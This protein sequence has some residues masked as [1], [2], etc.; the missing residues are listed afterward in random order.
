MFNKEF[1]KSEIIKI[2]EHIDKNLDRLSEDRDFFMSNI[3]K[4]LR[5]LVESTTSFI[6]TIDNNIKGFEKQKIIEDAKKYIQSEYKYEFL[7][8]FLKSLQMTSSHY[9]LYSEY[10]ERMMLTYISYLVQLKQLL[11]DKYEICVLN[12]LTKFPLD[13]DCTFENYYKQI[14]E[15]LNSDNLNKSILSSSTFYIQK[16]KLMYID[17]SI[18]YEYTLTDALDNISKFNRFIAYSKIDML[19]NYAI[20]CCLEK[21]YVKLIEKDVPILII[22]VYDVAIRPCE[23]N[24]FAY[25]FGLK[26]KI[27]RND[28]YYRLMTYIRDNHC[29]I[30]RILEFSNDK[31]DT[32]I[33]SL[34]NNKR[35]SNLIILLNTARDFLLKKK[36]GYNVVKYLSA[37]LTNTII[38]NQLDNKANVNVSNLYLKSGVLIFE[39]TPY[40]GSLIRHNPQS[41]ILKDL[42][43]YEEYEDDVFANHIINES[44]NKGLIYFDATKCD[45][46]KAKSLSDRYN[47]RITLNE[48]R[49]LALYDKYIYVME[50]EVFSR[51]IIE[52]LIYKSSLVNFPDYESYIKYLLMN[53]TTLIDDDQ[54]KESIQTMYKNSSVYCIYGAA[55]TGKSTLISKELKLLGK[56]TKLCLTNTHSAL[57]NLRQRIDDSKVVYKTIKSFLATKNDE[58]K[59]DI[60]VIDECS[61]I[62]SKDMYEVLNKV[63][64]TL[65]LLAGD[66]YQLPAIQFGNRFALLRNFIS[67]NSYIDLEHVYRCNE[68]KL[69]SKVWDSVRNIEPRIKELLVSYRISNE[70]DESV[71]VKK[72][73]DEIILALNYDGVFGI[74]YL[75]KIL[76]INNPNSEVSWRHYTYKVGDPIVFN[77]TNRFGGHLYNNLKGTIRNIKVNDNNDIIF[78]IEINIVLSPFIDYPN[79]TFIRNSKDGKALIELKVLYSKDTDYDEDTKEAYKVPFEIA[80]ALSIHKAQGLEYNSVKLIIT[81]DVEE[82]ISHNVFY[83]AITRAKQSL[84]IYWS[85]QSEDYILKSFEKSNVYKDAHILANKFN[86]P[87]TKK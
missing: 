65:L 49:C 50:N 58:T 12:N 16:K 45:I 60:V 27:N 72:D 26:E 10:A 54:K 34:I 63:E 76:Q 81:K 4:F 59:Y 82:K 2:C 68:N 56:I 20:K 83:T 18:F 69:L 14:N 13:L 7:R 48:E 85:R 87:L 70:I 17:G 5:D 35:Q 57:Q 79:F 47:A 24:K 61:T 75:N 52:H 19:K 29:T 80:Y 6:Y 37:V 41:Y 84:T 71:Y 46:E 40:S 15:L 28:Q 67:K 78:T 64:A 38:K 8:D 51:K 43:D 86:L 25:I 11:N 39:S 32:F 42:F 55:G 53:E 9:T 21:K 33:N 1:W 3:L 74:N 36:I 22:T 23:L 31:Y 44:N 30:T 62:S 66:I 73:E 77:E